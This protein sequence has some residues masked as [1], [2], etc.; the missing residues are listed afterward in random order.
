MASMW[1]ESIQWNI[2]ARE[3]EAVLKARK[4]GL[5]HL[6]DRAVVLHPEKVRRLQHSLKTPAHFPVLNPDE[7]DRLNAIMTLSDDERSRLRAALIATA[8]ERALMDRLEP[9]TALM[10]SNDVFE[11]CLAAMHD[12]PALALAGVRAGNVSPAPDVATWELM[13]WRV[14]L[15]LAR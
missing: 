6:D 5:G 14:S 8:A 7:L 11:I 9:Q 3:L 15:M 1:S 12:Q 10:A 4:L 13:R 2:F